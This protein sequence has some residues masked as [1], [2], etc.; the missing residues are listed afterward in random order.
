MVLVLCL[1]DKLSVCS[2]HKY[3]NSSDSVFGT[4]AAK[5]R[6]QKFFPISHHSQTNKCLC[7][8]TG[9]QLMLTLLH[10]KVLLKKVFV[11][12][13]DSH[14]PLKYP[15]FCLLCTWYTLNISSFRF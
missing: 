1:S 13:V 2:N 8:C 12:A 10:T 6:G 14:V 15:Q 5:V 4:S 7:C 9:D 11:L 3:H